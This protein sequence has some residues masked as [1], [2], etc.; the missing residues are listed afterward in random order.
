MDAHYRKAFS[1]I[2]QPR[3]PT[4]VR[5]LGG[6][7]RRPRTVRARPRERRKKEARQFGGLP[8]LGQCLLLTRRLVEAGVRRDHRLHRGTAT[9]RP[10]TPT[11]SISRLLKRSILPM[12]DRGFSALLTTCTTGA[13][14]RDARCGDGR[15]RPDAEGGPD[16]QQCRGRQGGPRP[17]A[18]LLHG[19]VRGRR[20]SRAARSTAPATSSPP[21]PHRDP[22]TPPD[23]AATI[24]QMLGI[25]VDATIHDP[26]DRPHKLCTGTPIKALVG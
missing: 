23:I 3:G 12:F 18:A 11:A 14:R 24:Y 22:V 10:G 4:R 8:H 17:L 13:A 1:L 15:V 7:R 16:H 21:T 25:E 20:A 6:A 2:L 26:L 19:P 9:T 5:P